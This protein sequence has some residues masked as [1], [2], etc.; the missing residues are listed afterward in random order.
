MPFSSV[1][2]L[3]PP[4]AH[5]TVSGELD[6]LSSRSVRREVAGALADGSTDF[7][8]DATDVTFVD[9]AGLGAFVH[10]RNAALARRGQVRFVGASTPFVSVC[11]MAGLHRAFG[12]EPQ[13]PA[14][15]LS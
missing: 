3:H 11:A 10:L 13:T 4:H 6:I 9:A 5:L 15:T 2:Q 14:H 8:V 12:L 7:T 1:I